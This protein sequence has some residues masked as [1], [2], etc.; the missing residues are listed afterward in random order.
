MVA[1]N[2][3]GQIDPEEQSTE[4]TNGQVKALEEVCKVAALRL[5]LYRRMKGNGDIV[6]GQSAR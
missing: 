4:P 5:G 1:D 3:Q 2:K 6:D